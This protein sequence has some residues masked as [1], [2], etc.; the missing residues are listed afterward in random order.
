[1]SDTTLITTHELARHLDDPDWAIFDCRFSLA[2][3]ERGRRDYLHEHIPGAIY[4]HINAELSGPIIPGVT[5]RHPLPTRNE[6]V[7][8]F[9]EWGIDQ[10]VQVVVYDDSG[11]SM[12]ARLWWLLRWLGHAAVAVLDGDWRKW[13]SEGRPIRDGVAIRPS[14][15]FVPQSRSELLITSEEVES[16]LHAD[17]HKLFDSRTAD[18]YRGENE[19]LDPIAGHIPGAISAPYPDNLNPDGTFRSVEELRARFTALLEDTPADH[20]AFYC[21]SGVTAAQNI[22]ALKHAGLG[23]AQLYAGSWSEWITDPH[24][25]IE[26]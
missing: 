6:L 10:R 3:P 16:R 7:A 2:D 11:G 4:A 15:R 8:R 26:N 22:L 12:A 25:P 13:K 5:G 20:A 19:T 24:R 17:Q 14:R 21:G 1:M 18:R 23:D 9:S